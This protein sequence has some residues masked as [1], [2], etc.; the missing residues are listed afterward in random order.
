MTLDETGTPTVVLS[1]RV[2]HDLM[3]TLNGLAGRHHRKPSQIAAWLLE[4]GVA[5]YCERRAKGEDMFLSTTT[6]DDNERR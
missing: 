5:D 4:C 3:A 6:G 1:V 2:S